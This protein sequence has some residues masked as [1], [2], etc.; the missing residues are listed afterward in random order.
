[1]DRRKTI[2]LMSVIAFGAAV[3][4]VFAALM[5]F[6]VGGVDSANAVSGSVKRPNIL[7]IVVDDA[8]YSDI[9]CYGGEVPTP[10]IDRLARE[11]M[12]FT[13]FHVT[14]NCAPTRAQL[15]SGMDHHLAGLG[16][17]GEVVSPNQKG[18]PGYEGYLNFRIASLA[19]VLRD[20]GYHTYM[21]G[22]W[23]LGAKEPEMR[24]HGRG[25]EETFAMLAGG[26]SHWADNR[27][28]IPGKA[29][30]YARNGKILK[31]L[32]KD[33]YSTKDY[34]DR[35]IEYIG[36]HKDDGRPFFGYLAYTAPHNPLHVPKKYIAKYK[37][38][39]DMGWDALHETRLKRIKQLGLVPE[40]TIAHPRPEWIKAWTALTD[41]KKK[42]RARDM[43]IYAAMIDYQDESIGRMFDYLKEIGQYENTLIIFF[44]DN[45]ASK[46]GLE[47]YAD[48][49]VGEIA[50]FIE[51]FDNSLK[52][53][54]LPSSYAS[55]GPGWAYAANTPFRLMKGYV[56]QGGIQVPCIMKMPGRTPNAGSRIDAF[57]Y[58]IDL[59]PT[60]LEVAGV[61]HPGSYRGREVLPM[62]GRSLLPL[63][64]GGPDAAF[65]VREQGFELYGMR[66]YRK[67]DWKAL[68]L[69][70]PYGNGE[71][72]LYNLA[73]DPSE[74]DDLAARHPERVKG[75]AEAWNR[76]ATENGIV[77]PEKP[78][79]YAKPPKQGLF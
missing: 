29:S 32:P 16:T 20:A 8:G 64:K 75:L 73:D 21:T 52:N 31:E 51:S 45:G 39:Y 11:G 19:E 26:A 68:R 38:K 48:L 79:G 3:G 28:L 13:Q 14:P 69:P 35:M 56:A 74:R 77:E 23:H 55:I 25:F 24:P 60:L 66:A 44:S 34:T 17:M 54:G 9:G 71:W 62:Q 15:L 50:D 58:V 7:L 37:G 6:A 76:Y 30:P 47:D 63:L 72:Q 59:M 65:A 70:K 36:V 53:R 57:T 5:V 61:E 1:M 46:T 18:K 41:E 12:Q 4:L 78:V 43:E 10:H 40:S 49:G 42:S 67:G 27:P 22:K 33:F 2:K